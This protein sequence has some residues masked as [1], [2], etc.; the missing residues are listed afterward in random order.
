MRYSLRV[1]LYVIWNI[2]LL[3]LWCIQKYEFLNIY[4]QA[5]V[6]IL[7]L[8]KFKNFQIILRGKPVQQFNIAED[9]VH[10]KVVIYRPQLSASS[11]EV[12]ALQEQIS[13][14]LFA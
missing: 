4:L 11:K 6:S 2:F 8:Q 13:L 1:I 9:L 10:K 3:I 5:Y 7:Y 12:Y 14:F